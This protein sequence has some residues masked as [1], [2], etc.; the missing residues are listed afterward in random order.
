M[1]DTVINT[2]NITNIFLWCSLISVKI[3]SYDWEW[4]DQNVHVLSK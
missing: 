1:Y 3:F 2:V 4:I